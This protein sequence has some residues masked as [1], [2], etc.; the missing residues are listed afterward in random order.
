MP[1]MPSCTAMTCTA[2]AATAIKLTA[3]ITIRVTCVCAAKACAKDAEKYCKDLQWYSGYRNGSVIGCLREVKEKLQA[4]CRKEVF[5][6]Q[7][8]AAFDYRA[9]KMLHEACEKDAETLCQ[10][11]K[12]GGGRI[13]ACL[14]SVPNQ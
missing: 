10:G 13:Q 2:T 11:V 5:K 1:L 3:C 7:L 9:D 8:D 14:V 6:V 12:N 4:G